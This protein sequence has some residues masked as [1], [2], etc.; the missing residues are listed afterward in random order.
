VLLTT[1]VLESDGNVLPRSSRIAAASVYT[2][3]CTERLIRPSL[4]IDDET[5]AIL[6]EPLKLL[7]R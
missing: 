7:S 4:V 6:A 5:L 2:G 3:T 1:A